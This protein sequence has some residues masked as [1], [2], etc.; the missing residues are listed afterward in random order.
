ML[1]IKHY[2][3]R[4]VSNIPYC[5]FG[6]CRVFSDSPVSFLI[7]IICVFPLFCQPCWR[8][9]N[10]IDPSKAAAR[11]FIYF[12]CCLSIYNTL[13][14]CLYFYYFLPSACL[15]FILLF[16]FEV[17]EARVQTLHFRLCFFS[18][19]CIYCHKFSFH[20]CFSSVPSILICFIFIFFSLIWFVISLET[21]SWTYGLFV[22]V[23]FCFQVSGD[24][25]VIFLLPISPLVP[26]W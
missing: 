19:V 22:S 14:F 23:L 3:C 7:L 16:F 17:L 2:V 8:S 13:D 25:P 26:V 5:P 24:L 18:T 1:L 4:G 9:V 20:H 12:L 21:S 11:S 10:F 6:V 15:S